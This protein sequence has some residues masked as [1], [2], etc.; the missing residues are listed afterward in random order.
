MIG[1]K[2]KHD[3]NCWLAEN[4]SGLQADSN[5]TG[6]ITAVYTHVWADQS[7][8]NMVGQSETINQCYRVSCNS[9]RSIDGWDLGEKFYLLLKSDS[10]LL[11]LR[12]SVSQYH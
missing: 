8:A 5:I 10:V 12:S 11:I 1:P 7:L 3:M 6:A 9:K 2:S 4:L